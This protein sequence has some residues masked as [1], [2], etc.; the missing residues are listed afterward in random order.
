MR[1]VGC[2]I[3]LGL[4]LLS[5]AAVALPLAPHRA[6]YDL[7]LAPGAD[8]VEAARG[9]I[10]IEF[11]GSSCEGYTT[12]VRQV[13]VLDLG[14]SGTRTLDSNS[15]TFEE[16]DASLLRFRSES[17]AD[18]RTMEEVDGSASRVEDETRVVVEGPQAETFTLPGRPFFPTEH[19]ARLVAEA[20]AGAPLFSAPVYDGTGDGRTVYD[21]LAV[22]GDALPPP[23]AGTGEDADTPLAKLA[24]LD[25]WPVRL[26][27]F[28]PGPGE[29]TPDYVVGFRLFE[30]G[31]SSDLT[32]AFDG[33]TLEGEL[34]ALELM[35][36]GD[37]RL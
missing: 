13:T 8:G 27:Y 25:S 18:G 10:A 9:R 14:E 20:E 11:Y 4:A 26:S 30:N 21:T 1:S 7:A 2:V 33:F 15:A 3:G 29:R 23:E 16:A 37:C 17:R 24:G 34:S 6:V 19:I 5:S 28:E 12:R 32:L 35:E 36:N 22:I 31:V